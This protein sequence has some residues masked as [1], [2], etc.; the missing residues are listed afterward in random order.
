MKAI[1]YTKYGSPDV[2]Q[3]T[4]VPKPVPR[5][6]EVLVKIHA[7]SINSWDWDMI[8]GKPYIVRMWGLFKP[9]HTIPGCDM[10]GVVEA[11]GEHV[12]NFVPGDEVFC[13][14]GELGFGAFAEYVCVPEDALSIKSS[15]MTFEQAAALPQAGTLALQGLRDKGQIQTGQKI[16]INGAAGG[17]GTLALQIAKQYDCE[18]TGVDSSE[19]FEMMRLMGYDHVIDYRKEDFTKS[20]IHY[21][22]ILD[23]QTNRPLA[24]Y[25]KALKR[26]GV[27]VTVGG[28]ISLLLQALLM[29]PFISRVNKKYIR[30][31][32]MKS[33][34]DLV[35]MNKLFEEGTLKPVIDRSYKLEEVPEAFTYFSKGNFIG[36]IVITV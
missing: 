5:Q 14:L 23:V 16:L 25:T 35:I 12:K 31:L 7:A 18:V 33:N 1:I 4:E 10:A 9:R 13:D 29:A 36:K 17:V 28:G 21:D 11:I 8:K 3:L 32:A 26:Y 2:L 19:K 30:I 6:N 24:H 34:R 27:Y 22:L 15:S 20:G